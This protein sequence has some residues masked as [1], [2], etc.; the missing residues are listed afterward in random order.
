MGLLSVMVK[1]SGPQHRHHQRLNRDAVRY[2]AGSKGQCAKRPQIVTTRRRLTV[3]CVACVCNRVARRIVDC[4]G[5]RCIAGPINASIQ[6]GRAF[7]GSKSCRTG[8]V[9]D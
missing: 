6:C 9:F 8:V 7:T 1:L 5:C 2:L 4:R 3:S